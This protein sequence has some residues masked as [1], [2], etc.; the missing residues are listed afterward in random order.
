MSLSQLSHLIMV[1]RVIAAAPPANPTL[2]AARGVGSIART[3][4]QPVGSVLVTPDDTTGGLNDTDC[5]PT[6]T[7]YGVAVACATVKVQIV[8]DAGVKKLRVDTFD[9]AGVLVDASFTF[10]VQRIN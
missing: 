1:G 4:G 3:A 6:A 8:D 7:L 2:I 5:S 10:A 9:A